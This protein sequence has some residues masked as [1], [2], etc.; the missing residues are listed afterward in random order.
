M[1]QLFKFIASCSFARAVLSAVLVRLAFPTFDVALLAWVGLVPLLSAVTP[2]RTWRNFAVGY[3]AGAVFFITALFWLIHVTIPG[4]IVLSLALALYWAAFGVGCGYAQGHLSFFQKLFFIPSLW[5]ILEFIRAHALTGFPWVLLAHSQALVPVAIQGADMTGAYGVSFVIV[6][7]NV[8]FHE[9][10]RAR[11]G[12]TSWTWVK[13]A[14]PAAILALWFAYGAF[15]LAEDPGRSGALKI[16]VVQGNIAQEIKWA[17]SLRDDIFQKYALLTQI[18]ALKQSP[19][20]IIWPETAFPDYLVAGENDGPLKDLA[21]ENEVPLL[22]GSIRLAGMRYYNSAIM[23]DKAGIP[24]G[25]YNKLHLVPFGEFL[26]GRRQFPW[27]VKILPIEDFTPGRQ[28]KMFS[29]LNKNGEALEV[30]VL[31]CFEDIFSDLASTFVRRGADVLVNITNDA[32]FGDTS[33]PY[34][35]LAS[36]IFRA[37]ENRVYVARA[38]NT[39]ISCIIDDAGRI[40]EIVADAA[41]K[42]T[43]VTG[44]QA[45]WIYRTHRQGL[46]AKLG[47]IFAYLCAL[48]VTVVLFLRVRRE[49][50]KKNT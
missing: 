33:S 28:Y 41:G 23:F 39:G 19:E 7:A 12:E 30:G 22:V 9:G 13:G 26:P 24:S 25:V 2:G 34:Q 14:V 1:N 46:Y 40:R 48:V 10:W 17:E 35:H 38:A 36:S 6:L 29:L 47:D 8:L 44:T 37:V 27:L 18:A 32:W 20:L 49:Y 15:R 11:C 3:V 45:G 43:F 50:G 4:M 42:K 16:S 5:V 21:R 31:I